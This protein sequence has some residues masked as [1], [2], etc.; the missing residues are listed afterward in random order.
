MKIFMYIMLG[1]ETILN[2][3]LGYEKIHKIFTKNFISFFLLHQ[4][5]NQ[6]PLLAWAVKISSVRKVKELF[7]LEIMIYIE[8]M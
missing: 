4:S 3:Q 8:K 6:E 2:L 7:S 5:N 1:H